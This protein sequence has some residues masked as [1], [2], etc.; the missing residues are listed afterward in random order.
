[1]QTDA[2]PAFSIFKPYY[3]VTYPKY[4]SIDANKIKKESLKSGNS[5]LLLNIIKTE[6]INISHDIKY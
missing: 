1:M 2:F 5:T 3:I 4:I 6:G